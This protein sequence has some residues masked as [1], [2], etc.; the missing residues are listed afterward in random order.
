MQ[1]TQIPGVK[2]AASQGVTGQVFHCSGNTVG[3]M[4]NPATIKSINKAGRWEVDEIAALFSS[5]LGME[6]QNPRPPDPPP[7]S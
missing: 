1:H 2:P 5:T 4:S 6:L 7:E 3:L